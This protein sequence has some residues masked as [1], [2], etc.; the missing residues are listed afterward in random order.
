MSDI[1]LLY[2]RFDASNFN[3]LG[4]WKYCFE[5]LKTDGRFS[6]ILFSRRS[7]EDW[8]MFGE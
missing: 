7:Y 4:H 3:Y 1:I 6:Y 8:K 2:N 5:V